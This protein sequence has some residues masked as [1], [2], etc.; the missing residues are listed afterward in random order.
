MLR[1]CTM[2]ASSVLQI[3]S[4]CNTK[5][6]FLQAYSPVVR[7][8]VVEE[9]NGMDDVV[10]SGNACTDRGEQNAKRAESVGCFPAGGI[11]CPGSNPMV[12]T[13]RK[14]SRCSIFTSMKRI[15]RHLMLLMRGRTVR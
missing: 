7:G 11:P 8:D 4:F 9:G 13:E 14:T 5:G 2:A 3:V 15:Q 1:P 6:I 10:V 12:F